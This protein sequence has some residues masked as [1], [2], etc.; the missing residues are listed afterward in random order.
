MKTREQITKNMED[1]VRES[2]NEVK[3][4]MDYL[5]NPDRGIFD[6]IEYRGESAAIYE[7]AG[8]YAADFLRDTK[9]M[10]DG[11]YVEN[12]ANYLKWLVFNVMND[13]SESRRNRNR[14]AAYKLL[15]KAIDNPY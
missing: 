9:D 1:L 7:V 11:K 4:F 13:T 5:K 8:A 10:G 2:A 3:R 6:A 15:W 14:A 12:A